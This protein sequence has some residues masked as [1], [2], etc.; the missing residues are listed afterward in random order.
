MAADRSYR[1]SDQAEDTGQRGGVVGDAA[2]QQLARVGVQDALDL[3]GVDAGDGLQGLGYAVPYSGER[4]RD[5]VLFRAAGE[6][7]VEGDAVLS[8]GPAAA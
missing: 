6:G 7:G 5:L 4:V 2:S 3:F 8:L 1:R